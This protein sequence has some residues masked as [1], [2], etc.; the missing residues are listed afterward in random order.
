MVTRN[1]GEG[2]IGSRWLMG[3]EFHFCKMSEPG[4]LVH[5]NANIGDTTELYHSKWLGW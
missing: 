5:N 3:T 2:E 4:D 1:Q